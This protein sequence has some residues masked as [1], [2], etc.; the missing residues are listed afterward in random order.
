MVWVIVVTHGVCQLL[1]WPEGFSLPVVFRGAGDARYPMI[2]AIVTMIGARI[3]AAYIL[4]VPLG[5][6]MLGTWYA[7]Y[8]DWTLR[9]IFFIPRYLRGT[10][11]KF[12]A[13]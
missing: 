12:R 10:W 9:I 8:V 11:L 1:I 4:A 3:V 5:M 6:G 2:V 7:M 13:I